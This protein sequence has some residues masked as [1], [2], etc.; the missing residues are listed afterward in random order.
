VPQA[1]DEAVQRRRRTA[2]LVSA[3]GRRPSGFHGGF[4]HADHGD[5]PGGGEHGKIGAITLGG[6]TV[7]AGTFTVE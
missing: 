1:L 4:L 2:I 6:T 7:S 3:I 5:S